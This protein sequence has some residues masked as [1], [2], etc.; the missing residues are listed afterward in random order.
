MNKLKSGKKAIAF[1]L[2]LLMILGVGIPQISFAAG[3]KVVDLDVILDKNN[4]KVG[5]EFTY[6][7]LYSYSSTSDNFYGE[8]IIFSLPEPLEF[9]SLLESVDVSSH[10]ITSSL[11]GTSDPGV[12]IY[13]KN[14]P[15]GTTGYV[16]VNARFKPGSINATTSRAGILTNKPSAIPTGSAIVPVVTATVDSVWT[17]DLTKNRILPSASIIPAY[18]GDVTYRISVRGNDLIGGFPIKNV[19]I[20]DTLPPGSKFISA[21][22][23]YTPTP[24]AISP[25]SLE[26]ILPVLSPGALQTFNVT[27]RYPLDYPTNTAINSVGIKGDRDGYPSSTKA[28]FNSHGI[29]TPGPVVGTV[30]KWSRQGDD[31]YAVGQQVVFYVGGYSNR[32]NVPIDEMEIVDTIPDGINLQSVTLGDADAVYYSTYQDPDNFLIWTTPSSLPI[33]IGTDHIKK[34][35]WLVNNAPV[36]FIGAPLRL[37]GQVLGQYRESPSSPRSSYSWGDHNK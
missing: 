18:G 3:D 35:R 30:T 29:T 2:T 23:S 37:S 32:G 12:I 8:E 27:V 31:R 21:T 34:V 16:R 19:K 33:G 9:V 25:T 13:M 10:A 4:V 15:P 5:E 1:V 6:T 28:A 17:W 22:G 14:L 11:P 7:I 24:T 36:G 20:T 26:W